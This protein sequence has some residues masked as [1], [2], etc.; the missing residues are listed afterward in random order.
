MSDSQANIQAVRRTLLSWLQDRLNDE[1]MKWIKST[2]EQLLEGAESWVFYSSFSAVPRHTGKEELSLTEKEI[3]KAEDLRTGWQPS[4]WSIDE[5]GRTLLILSIAG[6]DKD[7][8]FEKLENTFISSDIGEGIALYQSL[9]L[10]PHPKDLTERAAEGLRT[11]IT[12]I[13]NAV[14]HHNPYPADYL[15][16]DAWNQMVLKALFEQTP[17]YPIYNIDERANQKLADM[18]IDYAHERWAADRS[19]SPE[20]WRSVGPFANEE[21]VEKDLK[22]VL[23]NPNELNQQAALLALYASPASNAEKLVEKHASQLEQMKRD[24]VDWDS[25]GKQFEQSFQ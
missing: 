4:Y 5:L 21:T 11:N 9:P 7:V 25:I 18:L 14:A 6:E 3:A 15:D 8:F 24:N 19:V 20:L 16:D 1:A 23:N 22:K 10:L 13:F 12:S 2:S 17:L